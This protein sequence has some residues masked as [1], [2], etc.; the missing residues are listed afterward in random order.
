MQYKYVRAYAPLLT[1]MGELDVRHM[2]IKFVYCLIIAHILLHDFWP[3]YYVLL[4]G[5][6]GFYVV[7]PS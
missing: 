5:C 4:G 6:M 1:P 2:L 7:E 3:S